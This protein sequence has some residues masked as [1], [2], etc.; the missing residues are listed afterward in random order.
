MAETKDGEQAGRGLWR[1]LPRPIKWLGILA[2][3][4]G[5]YAAAGFVLVPALV[6]QQLPAFAQQQLQR[7]ASIGEVRFNPF[8]LR[9][10]ARDIK[11]E[12]ADGAPIAALGALA[13]DLDWA[14]LSRRAWSFAGIRLAEPRLSLAI[15]ADGRFNIAELVAALDRN[16]PREKSGLPRLIIDKLEVAGGRIDFNDRK[17]GYANSLT[18]IE[19]TL[20]NFSTLLDRNGPYALTANTARGGKVSWKGEASINPIAGSGQLMLDAIALPELG[21]YLKPFST[22]GIASGRLGLEARYRFSYADG[23][24]ALNLSGA[25]VALNDLALTAPGGNEAFLTMPALA[26]TGIEANLLSR[27]VMIDEVKVDGG[28]IFARR[29]AKGALDLAGLMTAPEVAARTAAAM[30]VAA[31]APASAWKLGIRQVG[32]AG[33]A[34]GLRDE[35]V[36]GGLVVAAEKLQL[37]FSLDAG[38]TG[39]DLR[40]KIGGL[41][42]S[43]RNVTATARGGAAPLRLDEAGIAGAEI[44]LALRSVVLERVFVNGAFAKLRID[45]KGRLNLLDLAPPNARADAAAQAASTPA[46]PAAP[47]H[48]RVAAVELR[49]LAADLE[50]ARNGMRF[51]AKEMAL[52]LAEVS[53]DAQPAR[54]RTVDLRIPGIDL[55]DPKTAIRVGLREIVVRLMDVNAD[56]KQALRFEA[57]FKLKEGGQF[58]AAGRVRPADASVDAS[59]KVAQLNLAP[60]Q[61]VLSRY[62]KLKLAGGSVSAQGR[63]ETGPKTLLRYTGG[64]GIAGLRLNDEDGALFLGWKEVEAQD[65]VLTLGPNE[66]KVAE[67]RINDADGKL[68]IDADRSLNAVK[69]LVNPQAAAPV[70]SA[71]PGVPSMLPSGV[72]VAAAASPTAAAPDAASPDAAPATAPAATGATDDDPFPVS[73]RRTRVNN[74]RLFFEDLSLRPQFGARIHELSGVVTGLATNRATRSRIELDGRVDEFG[75]ARIRGDL[76]PFAPRNNTDMNLV[77]KN[78]DLISASPYAMK[79]AGYKIA[80]GKISLDLKYK[81]KDSRLEGDNQVVIDQLTLGERVESP[82]A[83]N[84]PLELAIAILKDSDGRIDLGLPVSGSLDDPQFSYGAVV[85]KAIVN[86][87]TRIITAPFRALGALFGVSADK[88]EA[89]DFDAGSAALAP[90]EREKLRSI[91]QVLDQ[92]RQLKLSVPGAYSEK[93][94]TW[95]LKR[96][97][98]RLEMLERSGLKVRDG[99]EPGPLDV[100]SG[101]TRGVIRERFSARLGAPEYDRLKAEFEARAAGAVKADLPVWRRAMNLAQ[102]EPQLADP[103]PF[104]QRLIERL[105]ES[106]PVPGDA[107]ASLAAARATA[108]AGALEKLGVDAA[109]IA[110][111]K[112]EAVDA[113]RDAPVKLKLGLAGA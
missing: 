106:Q 60:L 90:P 87:I 53:V 99:E 96:R 38:Q 56:P 2:L 25:R 100:Q 36:P 65:V 89:V 57:G 95:A 70:A 27:E 64:I 68:L 79:F 81:V 66:L 85:W 55:E 19:F 92:R 103:Q 84:L 1:R 52:K 7:R 54:A 94:D 111:P 43:V 29:D 48:T 107:L 50:D 72:G 34:L 5:A 113:E 3:L 22:I 108:I 18:P 39:Q 16:P 59:L 31:V 88:L 17:A 24:P 10:E 46:T 20:A 75:S 11:L 44:D 42:A 21:P 82:D 58:N 49:G 40:M 97:A 109:R 14:S 93:A 69:L 13:V 61:P 73:V 30:P 91:A 26:V 104:Y 112:V 15:A 47:W 6:K 37:R 32:V 63:V 45:P 12:E 98:M 28:K 33:F 83:I 71:A 23:R 8:T 80:A 74:A 86:V 4:V 102:G 62:V 101:R 51:G 76:N 77:F 35:S 78:V 105:T 67:L 9:F 110:L 41:G